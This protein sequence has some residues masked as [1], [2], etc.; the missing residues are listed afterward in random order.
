MGTKY[1]AYTSFTELE[2]TKQ[3]S[4]SLEPDKKQAEAQKFS[5]EPSLPQATKPHARSLKPTTFT[6]NPL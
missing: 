4:S 5:L 3:V 1:R 2:A 6:L